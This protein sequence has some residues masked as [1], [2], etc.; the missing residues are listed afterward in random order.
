MCILISL[1]SV[2]PCKQKNKTKPKTPEFLTLILKIALPD[3]CLLCTDLA[4]L[5]FSD[6]LFGV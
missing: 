4:C 6:L 3:L 2:P 5:S 1:T